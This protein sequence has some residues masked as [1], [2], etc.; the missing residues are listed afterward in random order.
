VDPGL[1]EALGTRHLA[2]EAGAYAPCAAELE[3]ERD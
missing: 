1:E 3:D 2:Q